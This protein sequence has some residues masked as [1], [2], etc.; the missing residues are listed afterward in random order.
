MWLH[1]VHKFGLSF[2]SR[3][4][5]CFPEWKHQLASIVLLRARL[6]KTSGR[7]LELTRVTVQARWAYCSRGVFCNNRGM[8]IIKYIFSNVPT[9]QGGVGNRC[10][11]FERL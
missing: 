10:S 3:R 5:G 8:S 11:R 1:R 2:L 9:A 7:E 4:G 6:R